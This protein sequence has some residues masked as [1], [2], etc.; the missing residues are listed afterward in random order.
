MVI[1]LPRFA[2]PLPKDGEFREILN[3]A[4]KKV[5]ESG[6]MHKLRAKWATAGNT[7]CEGVSV[8]YV[9]ADQVC[10]EGKGRVLGFENTLPAFLILLGGVGL[11]WGVLA[12]EM[13]CR[14]HSQERS[15]HHGKAL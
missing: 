9:D 11:C 2:F 5:V 13:L 7:S 3:Y 1:L 15:T 14:G 6:E 8:D 10:E 12:C 4:I